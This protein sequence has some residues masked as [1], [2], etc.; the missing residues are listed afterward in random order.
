[1][2]DNIVHQNYGDYVGIPF[3]DAEGQKKVVIAGGL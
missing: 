1:M 3:V 2:N